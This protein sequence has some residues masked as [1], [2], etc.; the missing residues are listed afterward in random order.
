[1]HAL[2]SLWKN[3]GLG[4]YY[5]AIF[6]NTS[7]NLNFEMEASLKT[8]FFRSWS[9]VGEEYVAYMGAAMRDLHIVGNTCMKSCIGAAAYMYENYSSSQ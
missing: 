1:M 6:Q 2:K 5:L 4:W 7:S 9:W 8:Q 3:C